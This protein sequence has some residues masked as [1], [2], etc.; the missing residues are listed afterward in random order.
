[1]VGWYRYAISWWRYGEEGCVEAVA[2]KTTTRRATR[3][4]NP[5]Q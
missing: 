1:M 2:F 4:C 5:V 3:G